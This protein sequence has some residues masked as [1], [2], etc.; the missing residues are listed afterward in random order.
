MQPLERTGGLGGGFD[1]GLGIDATVPFDSRAEF[2]REARKMEQA[3]AKML[4]RHQT[5]DSAP[6]LPLFRAAWLQMTNAEAPP[7]PHRTTLTASTP[8]SITMPTV[9]M[10][11]ENM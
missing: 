3:V 9:S 5:R 7:K 1:G 6:A 8:T 4:P 2:Q 11:L 10:E